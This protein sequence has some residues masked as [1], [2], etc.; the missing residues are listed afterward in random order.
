MRSITACVVVERYQKA[1]EE[2]AKLNKD[3]AEKAAEVAR[4][5][6]V[7]AQ[8][9][10]VQA[11]NEANTKVAMSEVDMSKKCEDVWTDRNQDFQQTKEKLATCEADATT[12]KAQAR[13]GHLLLRP[14]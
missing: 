7:A 6:V 3:A 12:M 2:Q 1:A 9:E 4:Q 11:T 10:S 13:R 8:T 5:Q 14:N